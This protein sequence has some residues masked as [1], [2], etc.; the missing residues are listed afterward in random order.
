MPAPPRHPTPPF[1]NLHP[2]DRKNT[3]VMGISISHMRNQSSGN[4]PGEQ[5]SSLHC[6]SINNTTIYSNEPVRVR[7]N[8]RLQKR[9]S[10]VWSGLVPKNK[11][12]NKPN[13]K[14]L[15]IH[16]SINTH[17]TEQDELPA[18]KQRK[19]AD[20]NG[21]LLHDTAQMAHLSCVGQKAMDDVIRQKVEKETEKSVTD[22]S[23]FISK[24][25]MNDD[26]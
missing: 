8:P 7:P 6:V 15:I 11:R 9:G 17:S 5:I 3:A 4:H 14:Q 18:A 26:F 25:K 13:H 19:V 23:A 2:H 12:N 16:E 24:N 20:T 1:N 10:A 21:R 22:V